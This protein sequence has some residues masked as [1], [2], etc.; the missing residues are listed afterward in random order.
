[1]L[2]WIHYANRVI[3]HASEGGPVRILSLALL[4]LIPMSTFPN[5]MLVHKSDGTVAEIPLD[6]IEKVTFSIGQT[7]S[8]KKMSLK[9]IS[10]VSAHIATTRRGAFVALHLLGPQDVRVDVYNSNGRLLK[11]LANKS[12]P[13][14]RHRVSWDTRDEF[15][16]RVASG[17]FIIKAQVGEKVIAKKLVIIR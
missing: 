13:S 15:G 17:N 14:G 4:L 5:K 11:T 10:A 16:D 7:A 6:V 8:G 3:L 2:R 9:K 12:L 1:M